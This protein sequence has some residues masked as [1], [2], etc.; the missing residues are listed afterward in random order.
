[1]VNGQSYAQTH[2]HYS[3]Q[4][5]INGLALC[6]RL[7]F[8]IFPFTKLPSYGHIVVILWF[9]RYFVKNI[10][11]EI[12][13]I[14]FYSFDVHALNWHNGTLSVAIVLRWWS[15]RFNL[16]LCRQK[17]TKNENTYYNERVSERASKRTRK[18]KWK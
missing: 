11:G 8:V 14:L 2:T 1:M 4:C 13:T 18:K 10:I 12:S 7:I 5:S 9:S 16:N 15:D 17:W 3:I 6:C